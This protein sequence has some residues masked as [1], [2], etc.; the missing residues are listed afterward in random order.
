MLD[1]HD[2]YAA[3]GISFSEGKCLNEPVGKILKR[4]CNKA[5]VTNAYFIMGGIGRKEVEA[6]IAHNI[7]HSVPT[8][9]GTRCYEFENVL[10]KRYFQ[11]KCK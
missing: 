6:L 1:V 3:A 4:I 8:N 7:I 11:Q 10:A 2:K 5:T 9:D